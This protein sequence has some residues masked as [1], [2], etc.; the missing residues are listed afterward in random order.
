MIDTPLIEARNL[1]IAFG[2]GEHA[3][4]V[5]H[6]VSFT[7]GREKLGI[8]GESGAGKSTVGRAL[9]RLLPPAARVT[10]DRLTFRDTDLLAASEKQMMAL[11]GRRMGLILQDP[12]YSLNPV[13]PVGE[14]IAEAWRLHHKGPAREARERTLAIL[15]AVK[16]RDPARVAR[17][18]PHEISGGMGQR[19]MIAMML[20]AGPD[21]V[22]ADEPTSALDVTVRLEVLH[23]LDELIES[24]GLGL[25]LVSHDLNLVR[26]FCDRVVIMYA[27]RVME[28]LPAAD[29]DR[30]EHPY[31][32]GLL[33]SLPSIR[34]SQDRLPVLRRDPAWLAPAG[35]TP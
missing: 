12:K 20:I 28:T 17:L 29:L 14:Q 6:G 32:R 2:R 13:V 34:H 23:L 16:I 30:A 18:Y 33:A 26:R 4:P 35:G 3:V 7:L 11:R 31:T 27:G 15:E 21:V 25:I 22:I 8:V 5:V 10:A 24:R 19:V 1:R 9:M